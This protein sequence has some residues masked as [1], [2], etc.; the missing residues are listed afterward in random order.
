MLQSTI[1]EEVRGVLLSNGATLYALTTIDGS[2]KIT[3]KNALAFRNVTDAQ[4]NPGMQPIQFVPSAEGDDV[5]ELNADHVITTF[6]PMPD[7]ANAYREITGMI[8]T[9][10]TRS[11][12][13]GS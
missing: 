13:L 8:V 9:P 11:L 2:G 4:G 12:I 7:I 3:V 1:N 6:E 10:P 5:H